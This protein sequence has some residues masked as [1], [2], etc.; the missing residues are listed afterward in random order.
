MITEETVKKLDSMRVG[1]L[2]VQGAS[3]TELSRQFKVSTNTLRQYFIIKKIPL[4]PAKRR[5][6]LR[7]TAPI[8][9]KFGM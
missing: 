2:Y 9:E 7:S 1:D 5:P 8:G 4:H 3:C 6:S